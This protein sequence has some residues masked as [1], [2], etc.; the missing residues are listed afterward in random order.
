M[1]ISCLLMTGL[2]GADC[3]VSG[4]QRASNVRCWSASVV[5]CTPAARGNT[6]TLPHKA[7]QHQKQ[8]VDLS[9]IGKIKTVNSFVFVAQLDEAAIGSSFQQ[10]WCEL[11]KLLERQR[12]KG[13]IIDPEEE[14]NRFLI[15]I[16]EVRTDHTLRYR[17][18]ICVSSWIC[19]AE[20]YLCF[21]LVT[22]HRFSLQ[23]SHTAYM[24]LLISFLSFHHVSISL[25]Q[26][27]GKKAVKLSLSYFE[28][29]E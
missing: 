19:P 13:G 14:S 12:S 9:F 17:A 26:H 5:S 8:S 11:Q 18:D 20:S 28:M 23:C 10:K 1:F 24:A 29:P 27:F 2:A 22:G 25:F 15:H 21:C 6:V 3:G 4:V 16:N 7:V